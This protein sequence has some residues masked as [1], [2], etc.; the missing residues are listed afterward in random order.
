MTTKTRKRHQIY[1][2]GAVVNID[3]DGTNLDITPGGGTTASLR[4][5]AGKV[6]FFGTAPV[7]RPVSATAVTLIQPVLGATA[8][9]G[10]STT[11][12]FNAVLNAINK[13][14]SN[15]SALGLAS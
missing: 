1:M 2:A 9:Y 12:Q 11:A 6:G 5:A 15:N 13:M 10:F 3:F 4:L 14:I 7:S 8:A